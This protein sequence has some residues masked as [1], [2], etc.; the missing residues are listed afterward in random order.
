ME[1]LGQCWVPTTIVI[2]P[3][4]IRGETEETIASEWSLADH[5]DFHFDNPTLKRVSV[6]VCVCVCV[7]A[8][9]CVVYVYICV[10]VCMCV[11]VH[12]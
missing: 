10:C 5:S 2:F 12:V 1:A 4:E 3:K 8:C 6:C 9:A 7:C 11:Y